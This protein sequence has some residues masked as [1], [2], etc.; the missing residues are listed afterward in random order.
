MGSL[1]YFEIVILHSF[2][3]QRLGKRNPPLNVKGAYI[4]KT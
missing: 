3:T 2:P 4:S 1:K